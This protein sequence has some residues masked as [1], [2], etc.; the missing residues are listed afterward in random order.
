M[1]RLG[2]LLSSGS[3][4]DEMDGNRQIEVHYLNTGFPYTVTE[5]F[6][7]LFEGLTYA[8]ADTALAEVLHDQGNTYWTMMYANPYKYEFSGSSTNSYYDF[9]HTYEINDH[10][11]RLDEG[12][13]A[14]DNPTVLNNLDLPQQAQ[15]G[16]EVHHASR[17]PGAEERTRVHRNSSGSQVIWHDNI[18]P[19]NMTYEEL[20]ELG[21]AIGTHSR[22]LT[23]ERIASLPVKKYKCS[24]FSKKKTRHERCVICQM[25]YRRGDRQMIL[26]CK[27]SYHSVCVTRWLNI[28]KACP[29]C[30]VEVPAE[31]LKP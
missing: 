1:L 3:R 16:N 19:D 23:Q 18:D 2:I 7:D 24:L 27:H 4:Y 13:R 31:E 14:W 12:R 5:S 30:F 21:E 22:G 25:K 10:T 6:M 9:G 29:I 26:P 11:Q 20:L 17:N 28:N 15:H 8:Q